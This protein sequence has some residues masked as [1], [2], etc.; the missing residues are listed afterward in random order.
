MIPTLVNGR[1]SILLPEHRAA[2]PEWVTGWERER[3]DHMHSTT[4]P[5][6]RVLYV[7]A[8]ESEMCALLQMWG[9]SVFLVE[10]NELVIPNAKAIWDANGLEMPA[11]MYVGFCGGSDSV[12]WA[13]G[14]YVDSWPDCAHGPVIGDHGFKELRDPGER[15]VVT[16]DTLVDAAGFFPDMLSMDIEGAE[17]LALHGAEQVLRQHRPRLYISHHP[18]FGIDQYQVYS[19]DLRDW[20]INLGYAETL[21]AYEHELHAVYEPTA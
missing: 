12:N 11:G 13:H 7:G 18:E 15:P 14:V 16:I 21:L 9:A 3:L 1:W 5:G 17:T 10:P 6:D 4:K 2:R 8:E 20:I 19:R